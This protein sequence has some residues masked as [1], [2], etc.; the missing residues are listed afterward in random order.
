[1]PRWAALLLATILFLWPAPARAGPQN[2]WVDEQLQMVDAGEV[3]RF[4]RQ[5]NQEMG[6]F[7]GALSLDEMVRSVLKSGKPLDLGAVVRG[8][9]RCLFAEVLGNLHLLAR[10]VVLSILCVLLGHLQSGLREGGTVGDLAYGAC[11]LTLAIVATSGFRIAVTAA[12]SAM[13]G[14]TNFMHALVP[15]LL[16]LLV[17]TGSVAS[18]AMMFPFLT[19]VIYAVGTVVKELVVPLVVLSA[20]IE[21]AGMLVEGSRVSKLAGLL[22][23]TGVVILGLGLCCFLGVA[24]VEGATGAVVDGVAVRSAKFLTA[25]FV[26]VFGKMLA[27]TAEVVVGSSL[28]L[29]NAVGVAGLVVLALACVFP[30]LKVVALVVVYRVASALIQAIGEPRMAQCLASM[31]G[32]L[33]LVVAAVM[34]GAIVFFM[35][36]AGLVVTANAAVMLR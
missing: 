10:L 29:K 19:F 9:G 33:M 4:I 15:L 35:A 31:G 8:L 16:S 13:D 12:A 28:L 2:A 22:R 14:M 24:A 3:E 7:I 25:T 34:T 18:A 26:P 23:D 11:F 5:L 20:G 21:V 30:L 17:A 36:V 27:D 1:M 32:C 6:Q